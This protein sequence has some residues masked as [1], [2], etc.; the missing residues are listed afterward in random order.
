M[1][2]PEGVMPLYKVTFSNNDDESISFISAEDEDTCQAGTYEANQYGSFEA[3]AC[4]HQ[5]Y[6]ESTDCFQPQVCVIELLGS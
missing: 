5:C 4:W 6:L 2:Q 1:N 3:P